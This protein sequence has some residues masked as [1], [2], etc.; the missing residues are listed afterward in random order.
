MTPDAATILLVGARGP[1]HHVACYEGGVEARN[2]RVRG[3]TIVRLSPGQHFTLDDEASVAR[4]RSVGLPAEWSRW[5]SSDA[6]T[7]GLVAPPGSSTA[8]Q[9]P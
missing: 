5:L 8:A 3:Q 7:S 9:E 6:A 4:L 2:I 1:T